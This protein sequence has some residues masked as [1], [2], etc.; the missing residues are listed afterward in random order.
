MVCSTKV[1]AIVFVEISQGF[2][3]KISAGVFLGMRILTAFTH[4]SDFRVLGQ[5]THLLGDI[6]ALLLCGILAGCDDLL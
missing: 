6:L 1:K 3:T 4:V 5:V 2:R